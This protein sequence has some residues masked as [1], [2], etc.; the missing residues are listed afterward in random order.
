MNEFYKNQ[1]DGLIGN[2]DC[3]QMSAWYVFSMLGFYP[4]CPSTTQYAIGSPCAP[5]ATVNLPGG[6]SLIIRANGLSEKNIYIQSVTLSGK[7]LSRPF[8]EHADLSAGGELIFE[9]K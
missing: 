2:E 6:R 4:V 1:P 8:L 3:G 5:K 9:M 7:V